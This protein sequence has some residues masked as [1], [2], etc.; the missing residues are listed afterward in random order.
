MLRYT[1]FNLLVFKI[2]KI[3]QYHSFSY[4][5]NWYV[6]SLKDHSISH[7][8]IKLMEYKHRTLVLVIIVCRLCISCI[9]FN[10]GF[11]RGT[12]NAKNSQVKT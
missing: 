12:R 1:T 6:T 2:L 5:Y 8:S 10:L 11:T 7:I 3:N 4:R 9:C